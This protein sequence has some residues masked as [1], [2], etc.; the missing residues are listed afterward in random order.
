MK[1]IIHRLDNGYSIHGDEVKEVFED[2]EDEFGELES[3]EKLLWAILEYFGQ[4][5]NRHDAKRLRIV[6]ES[7]DKYL[8]GKE[9]EG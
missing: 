7:G 1:L 4:I 9:K 5:G 6:M 8:D 3:T 2:G